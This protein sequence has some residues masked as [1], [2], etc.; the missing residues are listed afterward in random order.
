MKLQE[1]N[2]KISERWVNL[3][4]AIEGI[5][6]SLESVPLRGDLKNHLHDVDETLAKIQE[7]STGL[8]TPMKEYK[9][10][11]STLHRPKSMQAGPSYTHPHRRSRIGD[12]DSDTY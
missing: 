3:E 2:G 5:Q 10:S 12:E 4:D 1:G 11:E 6:K 9:I 7:V 8:T